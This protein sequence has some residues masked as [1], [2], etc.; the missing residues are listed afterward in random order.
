M[1]RLPA[2]VAVK[3]AEEDE[4]AL[5]L[6]SVVALED[7]AA[8]RV[9]DGRVARE[10]VGVVAQERVVAPR[11]GKR[12]LV[13]LEAGVGLGG[14]EEVERLLARASRPAGRPASVHGCSM[15]PHR[16]RRRAGAGETHCSTTGTVK[17][18]RSPSCWAMSSPVRR[19]SRKPVTLAPRMPM[20]VR[21]SSERRLGATVVEYGRGA[22][23]WSSA[24]LGRQC[25]A[26]SGSLRGVGIV[27]ET[28]TKARAEVDDADDIASTLVS[29][30]CDRG[31]EA[32]HSLVPVGPELDRFSLSLP[33]PCS[34][35][36]FPSGPKIRSSPD[37]CC[38]LKVHRT[39]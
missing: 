20:S 18:G 26:A 9:L 13:L 35:S 1:R 15:R 24:A 14:C 11:D 38:R 12:R 33:L 22:G 21:S 31:C 8:A 27:A 19:Y 2:R 37:S 32:M 39:R 17:L 23:R 7:G 16:R 5:D 3:D 4:V 36:C 29:R 34:S 6:G 30:A 28:A 10:V 25:A